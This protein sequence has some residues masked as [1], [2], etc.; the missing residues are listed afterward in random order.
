MKK[1]NIEVTYRNEE[2]LQAVPEET[3]KRSFKSLATYFK[4]S[5]AGLLGYLA[6]NKIFVW[7]GNIG[8]DELIRMLQD[9]QTK[10][11]HGTLQPR[12]EPNLALA[13][14]F[15]VAGDFVSVS[16][17]TLMANPQLS[18]A[19]IACGAIAIG[20]IKKCIANRRNKK[21]GKVKEAEKALSM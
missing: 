17:A 1:E 11:T 18:A 19:V 7:A 6:S 15:E 12:M 14:I 21:S 9:L 2:N 5:I 16:W 4:G 20:T 3:E 8:Q 10:Y 13:K